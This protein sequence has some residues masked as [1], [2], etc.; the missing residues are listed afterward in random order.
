ML[1]SWWWQGRGESLV[2]DDMGQLLCLGPAAPILC[3]FTN[4]SRGGTTRGKPEGLRH[5]PFALVQGKRGLWSPM[6]LGLSVQLRC[7]S[8]RKL[9]Q[10]TGGA[11]ALVSSATGGC[12]KRNIVGS[13]EKSC[14][15]AAHLA[16]DL[17]CAQRF[18]QRHSFGE[19]CQEE[20]GLGFF[21]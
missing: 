1:A 14:L 7:W 16:Q 15:G 3:S 19:R 5:T 20:E 11:R 18:H 17:Q 6:E 2:P 12:D 4:C 21:T 13:H 10:V 8:D 9:P